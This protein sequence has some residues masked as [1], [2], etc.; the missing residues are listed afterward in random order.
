MAILKSPKTVGVDR[1]FDPRGSNDGDHVAILLADPLQE[2]AA[3]KQLSKALRVKYNRDQSWRVGAV[4]LKQPLTEYAAPLFEPSLHLN[5]SATLRAKIVLNPVQLLRLTIETNLDLVLAPLQPVDL[6]LQP[7]DLVLPSGDVCG[8]HVLGPLLLVD[9][10]L[11]LLDLVLESAELGVGRCAERADGNDR[12]KDGREDRHESEQGKAGAHQGAE[13]IG[14][15]I[16]WQT[17]QSGLRGQL[18][19]SR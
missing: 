5:L 7:V 2:L 12:P 19:G 13:A 8:E 11:R 15:R 16:H 9:L 3:L 18:T 1:C 10:R 17:L 6:A 4:E 14:H